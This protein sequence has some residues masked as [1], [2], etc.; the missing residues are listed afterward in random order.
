MST[1]DFALAGLLH[2]IGLFAELAGACLPEIGPEWTIARERLSGV[3]E[4]FRQRAIHTLQFVCSLSYVPEGL[5]LTRIANIACFAHSPQ[6]MEEQILAHSHQLAHGITENA[7]RALP[8]D[9]RTEWKPLRAIV[10]ALGNS[11]A[12]RAAS[13][14]VPIV[15]LEPA[16]A[17]PEPLPDPAPPTKQIHQCVARL[18][19]D[20]C[21]AW[22]AIR[23]RDPLGFINRA[24]AVLERFTWCIATDTGAAAD[25]SLFDHAKTTAA[26]AVCLAEAGLEADR[27]FLLVAADI[28]GIQRYLF[29]LRQGT[30]GLARRLRARS[31]L[32][33]G[34]V[35]SLAVKL[36]ARLGLPLTQ[37]LL[38]AGGKVV[39]LL[40]NTERVRTS[41]D[42]VRVA[43]A[44]W[45]FELSQ[46][47]L[48]LALATME[49]S[50]QDLVDFPRTYW[51]L[52]EALRGA[53]LRA[54]EGVLV[55]A[56]GWDE[57]AFL[58]PAVELGETDVRCESCRRRRAVAPPP[59]STEPAVCSHCQQE[60]VLGAKLPRCRYVAYYVDGQGSFP[61]PMGSLRLLDEAESLDEAASLPLL[62]VDLDGR[63]E[64]PTHWP[65]VTGFRSRYIPR[66]ADGTAVEFGELAGRSCGRPLLGCLKMD[67]DNLGYIFGQALTGGETSP[68]GAAEQATG[69]LAR[70]AG[71]SRMLEVF[72]AGYLETLLREKYPDVYLVYSGGD[73]LV[74]IGPWDR[75][76]ELAV[77]IREDFR[78]FTAG[79]PLW[80]LS[81]GIAVMNPHVPVLVAVDEAERLLEFSKSVVGE[82][83]IAV[84]REGAKTQPAG[85]STEG[86]P[87]KNRITVFDTSIPWDQFPELIRQ[88]KQLADWIRDEVLSTSQVRRLLHYAGLARMFQRTR[89]TQYLQ[90]V[91]YLARDLRR[92]W[93]EKTPHHREAKE[94][95][96]QFLLPN[97]RAMPALWFVCHYALYATR[98]SE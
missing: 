28:P 73:D 97:N 7:D 6:T 39:L 90:Y 71:L 45:I 41:V 54:G 58:L 49:A 55:D 2:D 84:E 14:F 92:T 69:S 18:W 40:P 20:F 93:S 38:S 16:H 37:R 8:A 43:V 77:D 11:A 68:L 48:A 19:E 70:L 34:Y 96:S 23:C 67:A 47:E 94:W 98:S 17:F 27:P 32:V 25:T 62:I 85:D 24:L 89:D 50:R 64:G 51:R 79:S 13:Y 46:G 44:R 33:A 52:S 10:S 57:E 75:I 53:R 4:P 42:E 95:A 76:L 65:L 12:D 82:G 86:S 81:A 88:A 21:T 15:P 59:G 87:R 61:T 63:A 31:F 78:R 3:A 5:N 35:D 60:V 66:H 80:S 74:A 56:S 1:L 29:N 36:L 22:E 30:G 83:I 26:V 9:S 72:F 91:P